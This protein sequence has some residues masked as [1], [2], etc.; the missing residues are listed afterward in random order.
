MD[1]FILRKI[2]WS[3]KAPFGFSRFMKKEQELLVEERLHGG[4]NKEL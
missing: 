3:L 4:S 2:R 1:I